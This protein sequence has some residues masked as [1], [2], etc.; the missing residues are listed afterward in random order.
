M[1]EPGA[2]TAEVPMG[3]DV[4]ENS[5]RSAQGIMGLGGGHGGMSMDHMVRDMRNRFGPHR[6]TVDG[7]VEPFR[8]DGGRGPSCDRMGL[9][10][11]RSSR[12]SALTAR[13]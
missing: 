7:A 1:A 2:I 8:A 9:K 12:S 13:T 10:P 6:P 11:S 4:H 5:G 3:H